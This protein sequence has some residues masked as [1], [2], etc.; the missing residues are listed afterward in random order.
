M[1]D[2][3][4]AVRDTPL[5][6]EDY[7]LIGDCRTAALVGKDGG[8]DWLCLPRF[9]SPACFAAL[10]G[11]AGNGSWLL[12]PQH[13]QPQITR[14]YRGETL[15]LETVFTTPD[16]QVAVIDAM[17]T[18]Q[19]GSHVVR[20]VEGRRGRVA[21]R[22]H[23]KLRF[24][25]GASTPWVTRDENREGIV[26]IVGPDQVT[27][28]GPVPMH[29]HDLATVAAFD[30][31][32]GQSFTFVLSHGPSHLPPPARFD[33]DAALAE[34]ETT[35]REWSARCKYKGRWKD[36]VVRSLI[37]LKALSYQP[38][39]GI[40]AAPTTSLPEQLGGPR[41]WDYRFCWLR[42]A[43][44]TLMALMGAGYYAEA[45]AWDNWLHR[46]I[47]GN[48]DEMQIM[49]GVGGE[50]R[51]LEWEADWL[52]GYQGA[53]PVRIGNA[54]SE[55]RQL[56]VYG[57]VMDAMHQARAGGLEVPPAAWDLQV[58]LIE[59]LEAIW[60]QAD[61]GI[62]EVRGGRRQFVHSKVMAWVAF[63]RAVQDMEQYGLPG[64]I[65]RWRKIRD[66]I[67]IEVCTKGF[68]ETT[69]SFAQ[70]YD[71]DELD[72][73]LLMIPIVGFLPP[74]DP[75]VTGTVAAIER[76]L[77]ADGFVLRYRT[78]AGADGLP[79]GE[80]AFLPCSFWLADVYAQQ[81]RE[82]EAEALFERLLAL[83]NDVGLLAE[84]YDPGVHRQVGNF[85]Q[86]FSHLALVN[87]ALN[88]HD[89]S[90]PAQRAEGAQPTDA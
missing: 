76:E 31:E 11:R 82:P 22:M 86:A 21:M 30:V 81:G 29:G 9:D 17:P 50:R 65:E 45:Q 39:G 10:L 77:N 41:N 46:S 36:A 61:E 12:T 23:L 78:E 19:E 53:R 1:P 67:H 60:Q 71:S 13:T 59:H 16:G 4:F 74:D 26:A 83:R 55:Q 33:G 80:G 28:R 66:D 27:V 18:G 68:R 3:D 8:I 32:A 54:A 64:P 72:A 57:E 62:W 87:T 73:S 51:L 47:A 49:Y 24:D 38:T 5:P 89:E 40:V 63:D 20:R 2:L 85:P 52:V 48:A 90:V 15:I 88:L 56:D 14:S 69:N 25:Y 37:V 58:N 79:P 43:T 34:T 35:W 42:D 44:L 6:I 75:R 7:A 70:S 84:E